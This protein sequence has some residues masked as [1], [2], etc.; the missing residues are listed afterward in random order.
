MKGFSIIAA[1][2]LCLALL[3][4]S[5]NACVATGDSCDKRGTACCAS[6]DASKFTTCVGDQNIVFQRQYTC[7]ECDNATPYQCYDN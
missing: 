5:A 4:G 6:S 1:T 2:A 7:T 3:N